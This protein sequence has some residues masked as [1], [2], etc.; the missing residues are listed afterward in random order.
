MD[1]RGRVQGLDPVNRIGPA[2][3]MNVWRVMVSKGSLFSCGRIC[4]SAL[5]LARVSRNSR[6]AIK[7]KPMACA[8]SIRLVQKETSKTQNKLLTRGGDGLE[9]RKANHIRSKEHLE[10]RDFSK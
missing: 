5:P 10:A 4:L 9:S 7:S 8:G 3:C 6:R 1:K 2:L